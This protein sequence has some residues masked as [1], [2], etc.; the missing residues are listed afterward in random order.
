MRSI[1]ILLI[2]VFTSAPSI[3]QNNPML[4]SRGLLPKSVVGTSAQIAAYEIQKRRINQDT[5]GIDQRHL[6]KKTSEL[7]EGIAKSGRLIVNDSLSSYANHILDILLVSD[8]ILRSKLCVYFYYSEGTNAITLYN[9][10]IIVEVGLMAHVKNEAQLAFILSHEI[11]HYRENHF[12]RSYL[13]SK[14]G[15]SQDSLYNS[16]QYS[17]ELEEEA[18]SLGFILYKNSGYFISEASETFKM[19][20]FSDIPEEQI[21]FDLSFFEHGL[22]N[23]PE[24]Y[25]EGYISQF[26]KTTVEETLSTHPSCESRMQNMILLQAGLPD[27]GNHYQLPEKTFYELRKIAREEC[28]TIYLEKLDFG[29]AIYC[30]YQLLKEDST[31]K[32]ASTIIGKGLY[33]LSAYKMEHPPATIPEFYILSR[34]PYR[35]FY[36]PSDETFHPVVDYTLVHGESQ[37]LN[38]FLAHLNNL[39]TAVLALEWNW[40]L[41]R[42]GNYK[43]KLLKKLCENL[44]Q[45]ITVYN[46]QSPANFSTT[47]ASDSTPVPTTFDLDS[48]FYKNSHIVYLYRA[49]DEILTDSIFCTKFLSSVK[50]TLPASD[51]QTNPWKISSQNLKNKGGLGMKNIYILPPSYYMLME[52]MHTRKYALFQAKS[53][54]LQ[55]AQQRI[56]AICAKAVASNYVVLTPEAMDSASIANY[57][58]YCLLQ[59][60]RSEQSMHD[61]NY[62]VLNLSHAEAIDSITRI[63]NYRYVMTTTIIYLTSVNQ[64]KYQ[65]VVYDL[66]KGTLAVYYEEIENKK[67]NKNNM[68]QYYIRVFQKLSNKKQVPQPW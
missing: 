44:M 58:T 17:R 11:C 36:F 16:L 28:C 35:S 22:Y 7:C 5:L 24:E 12:L 40:N 39:E 27:K 1:I 56:T 23:F 19:L 10:M 31:N 2:C 52:I 59:Q 63:T 64:S 20:K 66:T 26:T 18:D 60:W 68:T 62:F 57:N 47:F 8:P 61:P 45:M 4:R 48:S 43:D 41:Y 38:F 15:V 53:D 21:P 65:T 9:G 42:L 67:A 37:K 34:D 46:Q 29:H 51:F 30:A 54:S 32:I 6:I 14:A 49:F 3:S 50:Q 33:N 25:D 55:R 13:Y